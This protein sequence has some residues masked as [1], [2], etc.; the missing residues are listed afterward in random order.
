MS[1]VRAID[2]SIRCLIVK[3]SRLGP[4]EYFYQRAND[5]QNSNS[6]SSSMSIH[7]QRLD[8]GDDFD[9]MM[10]RS[11]GLDRRR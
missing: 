3:A 8:V 10:A 6:T 5:G 4:D 11:Q 7:D 2:D 9:A 1:W